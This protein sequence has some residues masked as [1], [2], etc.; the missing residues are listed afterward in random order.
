MIKS[1]TLLTFSFLFAVNSFSA[2][3]NFSAFSYKGDIFVT[4]L[5]DSCNTFSGSLSVDDFCKNDRTIENKVIICG[6]DLR[7]ISTEMAC[8]SKNDPKPHVFKINLDKS[9]IAKEASF[10]KIKYRGKSIKL[11]LDR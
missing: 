9:N 11:K 2:T 4:V 10:L 8:L 6:V 3:K 7:V 5:G 1:L